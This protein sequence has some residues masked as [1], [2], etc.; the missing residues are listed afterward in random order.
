MPHIKLNTIHDNFGPSLLQT[1][2]LQKKTL[3]FV[4][5]KDLICTLEKS[6]PIYY[7]HIW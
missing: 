1:L 5:K 3:P 7:A 2:K 6:G 4:K